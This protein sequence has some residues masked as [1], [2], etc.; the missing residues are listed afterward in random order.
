MTEP[1]YLEIKTVATR[2]ERLLLLIGSS[3]PGNAISVQAGHLREVCEQALKY[4]VH[5]TRKQVREPLTGPQ[6]KLIKKLVKLQASNKN[7]SLRELAKE[8]G[9]A[10]HFT[11][12]GIAKILIE[13]GYLIKSPSGKLIVMDD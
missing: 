8:M 6:K 7:P 13:N 1:T 3:N 9:Y 5:V 2:A 4:H 11:V 10:S 12:T